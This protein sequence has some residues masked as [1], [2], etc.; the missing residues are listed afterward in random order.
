M[1]RGVPTL[2]GVDHRGLGGGKMHIE[3]IEPKEGK[4]PPRQSAL[5]WELRP[6]AMARRLR[7]CRAP[8]MFSCRISLNR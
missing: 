3:A 1:D 5:A 8:G 2:I 7:R 6:P 4:Q